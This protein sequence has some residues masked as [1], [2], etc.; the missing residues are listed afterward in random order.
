MAINGLIE[1]S[2]DGLVDLSVD[3]F[4]KCVADV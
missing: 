3:V 2:G 1:V 4:A